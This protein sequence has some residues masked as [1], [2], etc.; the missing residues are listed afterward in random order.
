MLETLAL[1]IVTQYFGWRASTSVAL[2]LKDISV[3][4]NIISFGTALFK[5]RRDIFPVGKLYMPELKKVQATLARY[6]I[7]R[8]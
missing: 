1:M 5:G 6:I 8:F 3:H 4:N 2:R 7:A